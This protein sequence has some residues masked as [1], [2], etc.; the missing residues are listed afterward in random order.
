MMDSEQG[1]RA[2]L[3]STLSRTRE[4]LAQGRLQSV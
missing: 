2:A 3:L 4:L 1:Y